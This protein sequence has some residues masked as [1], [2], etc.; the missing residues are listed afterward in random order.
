MRDEVLRVLQVEGVDAG[1][2]RVEVE[3]DG[4]TASVM[5]RTEHPLD[6]RVANTV[7]TRVHAIDAKGAWPTKK[8]GVAVGLIG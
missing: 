2:V 4:D 7:A 1:E 3:R 8:L 6:E 5:V